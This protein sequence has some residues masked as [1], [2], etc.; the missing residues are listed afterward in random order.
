MAGS[1]S[2]KN[3]AAEV[4]RSGDRRVIN[5][6][7]VLCQ[8]QLQL[9]VAEMRKADSSCPLN[10]QISTQK[11]LSLKPSKSKRNDVLPITRGNC[12]KTCFLLFFCT[13]ELCKCYKLFNIFYQRWANGVERYVPVR[14]PPKDRR[15]ITERS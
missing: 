11:Q 13:Q 7:T 12:C 1:S 8:K 10:M 14:R 4:V 2:R 5:K 3:R 15:R 9:N 6:N